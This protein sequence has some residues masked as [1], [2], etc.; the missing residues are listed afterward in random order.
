LV[1]HP[2]GCHDSLARSFVT[3]PAFL[4]SRRPTNF[5]LLNELKQAGYTDFRMEP[6]YRV[7]GVDFSPGKGIQQDRFHQNRADFIRSI[8]DGG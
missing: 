6:Q 3:A 1:I 7:G 4:S 2:P 8:H 5:A